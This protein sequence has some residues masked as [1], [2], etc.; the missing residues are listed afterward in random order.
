[1]GIS[2]SLSAAEQHNLISTANYAVSHFAH[3]FCGKMCNRYFFSPQ[4]LEDIAGNV[5][6]KAWRSW[7][8]YNPEVAS[9]KTWV[10][11]IAINCVKDAV[12]YKIKRLPISGSLSAQNEDEEEFDAFE[13]CDKKRGFNTGIQERFSE[14]EADRDINRREFE[15]C[16]S[17][18]VGRL[19]EKNQRFVYML[20]EGYS[21]KEMVA[22]DGGSANAVYKRVFDIRKALK[23]AIAEVADEFDIPFDRIAG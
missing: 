11:R 18:E 6:M 12:D 21:R 3:V 1:M 9:V 17:D 14:Y 22:Q 15:R 10:S 4:D 7:D 23:D 19:S 20:K 5:I 16:V 2:R 8:R 13:V